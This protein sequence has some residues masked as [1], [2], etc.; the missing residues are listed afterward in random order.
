MSFRLCSRGAQR[1]RRRALA[2][3]RR[4]RR[5]RAGGVRALAAREYSAGQRALAL[6]AA[7]RGVPKNTTSPPRSPGP[8]PM[9]STRSAARITSGSCSTTSSVLPA[10]RRRCSTP[11]SAADVARVQADARLV[12]DEQGVDQ[13]GAER[14]GEVDALHLAA[15]ERARLAVEREVAEPD[16]D[17]VAQPGADLAEQQLGRLVERRGQAQLV[18]ERAGSA[19]IGSSIDVVDGEPGLR[20]RAARAAPRA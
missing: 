1:S 4:G 20:R 19:S 13:R 12:E 8:G 6:A 5:R 3:A 15:A 2:G 17:Q 18:E 14:G 7:P 9:S 10:S 11:I 16:V